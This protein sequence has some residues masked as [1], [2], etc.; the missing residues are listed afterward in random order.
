VVGAGGWGDCWGDGSGECGVDVTGEGVGPA[1]RSAF[2]GD[3]GSGGGAGGIGGGAFEADGVWGVIVALSP[4]A[5]DRK[6]VMGKKL[7]F[8]PTRSILWSKKSLS[9]TWGENLV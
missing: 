9:Y 2:A 5:V 8:L 4:L 7:D 3:G 6:V 1:V